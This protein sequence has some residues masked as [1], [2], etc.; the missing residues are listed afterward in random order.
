M[1]MLSML[2]PILLLMFM[3]VSICDFVVCVR[4]VDDIDVGVDF[5]VDDECSL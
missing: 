4:V 1:L 5:S 3:L 2:I